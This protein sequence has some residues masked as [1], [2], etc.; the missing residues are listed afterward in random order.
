MPGSWA[1]HLAGAQGRTSFNFRRKSTQTS[2]ALITIDTLISSFHFL[3]FSKES[4]AVSFELLAIVVGDSLWYLVVRLIFISVMINDMEHF[5]MLTSCLSSWVTCLS[6][7]PSCQ[8]GSLTFLL[9][10]CASRQNSLDTNPLSHMC[11][12]NI[13]S[14]SYLA[15]AYS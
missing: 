4:C 10:S 7:S 15:Y 12:G 2:K 11:V 6:L 14:Q 9:F 3:G 8:L 13:F 5:C 1:L